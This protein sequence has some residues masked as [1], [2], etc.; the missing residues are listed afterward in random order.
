MVAV[1][2]RQ[3][4]VDIAPGVNIYSSV[5]DEETG[6]LGWAMFQG[7]SMATPHV[8]G[9]A[10]LLLDQNPNLTPADVK[11]L[12]G[13]NAERNVWADFVDG[14]LAGLMDR[15]GGRIDLARASAATVT[16]D[17]MSLSFGISN[18]NRPV[19]ESISV[20]VRNLSATAKELSISGGTEAMTFPSNVTVPGGGTA[21]FIVSLATRGFAEEEG[22]LTISDGTTTYLVPFWYSNGN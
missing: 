5:F 22:D 13:N 19:N 16:F 14:T 21:T 15:G 3:L 18:G 11:S 20:T 7:T 12:L 9:A 2:S 6:V 17:P 8:A 10:A 1:A 4:S